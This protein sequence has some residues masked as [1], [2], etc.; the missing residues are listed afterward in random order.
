MSDQTRILEKMKELKYV[1]TYSE[2]DPKCSEDERPYVTSLR[3]NGYKVEQFPLLCPG[4]WYGF[5]KLDQAYKEKW[6][7]LM[8][9]Y[10]GLRS[11][12]DD[13]TV[14]VA[15]AGAMLHPEFIESLNCYNVFSC[16]DDP[17]SSEAL[18]KPVCTAFDY[19][20]PINIA[21]VDDYISWGCKNV[22]WMFHGVVPD[23]PG[24][25]KS[26]EQVLTEPRGLDIVMLCERIY[27]ASDRHLRVEYLMKHFP[28]AIVRGR[29]W[30]G[31]FIENDPFPFAKIGWNLHNSIGPTNSRTVTLPAYG[32]L[33]IC[34]N[35]SNLGKMFELDREVVGFDTLDECV[36]K[37]RYYLDHEDEAREIAA[38][39]WSRVMKDYTKLAQWENMLKVIYSDVRLKF[40]D[41]E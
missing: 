33:Q 18:S 27:G 36:D 10:D 39:G 26:R 14:L 37:T 7:D 15:S 1:Y 4:G 40:K 25:A 20:L 12:V 6:P 38:N 3:E 11:I 5:K 16:A 35:K 22:G 28:Q 30:P 13:R 19:C 41:W 8:N 2:W 21:C 34:D 29:G 31:G 17:E 9:L 32:V 23:S 24:Y